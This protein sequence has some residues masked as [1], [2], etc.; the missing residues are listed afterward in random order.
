MTSIQIQLVFF[1]LAEV[2]C[3]L[4]TFGYLAS[5]SFKQEK[6]LRVGTNF[7]VLAAF[8]MLAALLL[9]WQ[10]TNHI[11]SVGSY[12]VY[13]VYSWGIL[14]F[15]LLVQ[16]WKKS[17]QVAGAF[18]LPVV[19]LMT[20]VGLMGSTEVT[21]LPSTYYTYWL[22]IHMAFATL[23]LGGVLTSAGL[24]LIYV[25]KVRQERQGQMNPMFERLPS[26]NQL[27]A[28]SY[29]FTLFAFGMMGIMIA[30]GAIWAYRSWGRYWGWD[31][32]E[33]WSLI[34]WLVY[35]I[36]L[37]LRGSGLKGEKAAWVYFLVIGLAVFSFFGA[38]YLYPTIHDRFVN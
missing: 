22:W 34:C 15:Y 20:G 26:L 24:S 27:D 32:I 37:H 19:L 3:V 25:L 36:Y 18:V 5:F 31:P 1:W 16:F 4:S 21:S 12:E 13:T 2:F 9:R 38:P 8:P 7:A 33:T 14:V 35:G 6:F 29:R 17:A 11:P 10:E 28:L 30:S 23:A